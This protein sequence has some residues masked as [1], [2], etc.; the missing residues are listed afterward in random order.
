MGTGINSEDH[1]VREALQGRMLASIFSKKTQGLILKGGLAMRHH[2][3]AS[4]MT[5]DIDLD[6]DP[7]TPS[8]SV[9]HLVRDSIKECLRDSSLIEDAVVTEPKQTETTLRWKI[10]GKVPGGES[11]IHL[12]VEISR[13][14][15]LYSSESETLEDGKIKVYSK[16]AIAAMKT[17]ALTSA[18]RD[19]PRD[20]F[21]L[22][23]LIEA[24][25]EP[26][27]DLLA[28]LGEK[29]LEEMKRELWGKIESYSYER[30][31]EEVAPFLPASTRKECSEDAWNGARLTVGDKLDEWLA[32]SLTVA[33]EPHC[34]H[35]HSSHSAT[36]HD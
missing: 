26:P 17:E 8:L 29:R 16:K 35:A 22:W 28:K 11:S 31:M 13:R 25:V 19:A 5:K 18:F 4:R 30:F 12:T 1:F 7:K 15:P 21:D 2:H 10:V 23:L 36:H 9:R 24:H 27:V 34:K 33:K 20:L 32:L 3:F 14:E 6:S